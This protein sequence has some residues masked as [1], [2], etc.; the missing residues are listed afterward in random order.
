MFCKLTAH[1]SMGSNLP[2]ECHFKEQK[3][4]KKINFWQDVLD[5]NLARTMGNALA[6]QLEKVAGSKASLCE[7]GGKKK[8]SEKLFIRGR[9]VT[10]R[11]CKQEE[12]E[13]AERDSLNPQ[14]KVRYHHQERAQG[15]VNEYS[16]EEKSDQAARLT[17]LDDGKKT[18]QRGRT[19][20]LR[21]NSI[22]CCLGQ[23]SLVEAGEKVPVEMK[24][25][26]RREEKMREDFHILPGGK[27][28]IFGG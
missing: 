4:N 11:L 6:R 22:F 20:M 3:I 2:K 9:S 16:P 14:K 13:I 21:L 10:T 19:E 24:N 8:L 5:P 7:G 28:K 26:K 12:N 17:F 1:G 23:S 18:A 15:L 27:G 25:Q